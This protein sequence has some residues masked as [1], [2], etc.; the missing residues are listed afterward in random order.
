MQLQLGEHERLAVGRRQRQ[1]CTRPRYSPDKPAESGNSEL[2][3]PIGCRYLPQPYA[4]L[5]MSGL[6]QVG[7]QDFSITASDEGS[8]AAAQA[9]ATCMWMKG[10]PD[11]ACSV[12]RPGR[13][14]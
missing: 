3:S 2:Q 11:I 14:I 9:L 6:T 8:G 1:A 13:Y 5:L 10:L 12:N 4:A 7:R